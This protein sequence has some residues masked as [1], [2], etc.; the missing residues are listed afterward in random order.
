MALWHMARKAKEIWHMGR[1]VKE[2]WF[3]GR[4]I[5]RSTPEPEG[6]A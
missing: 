2:I 4:R 1:K 3:M 5:Y 6:G